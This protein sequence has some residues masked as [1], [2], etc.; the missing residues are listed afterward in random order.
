MS[1]LKKT[2]SLS[3]RVT[4]IFLIHTFTHAFIV[5]TAGTYFLKSKQSHDLSV[6]R[7]ATSVSLE[8]P[9]YP[10]ATFGAS[11]LYN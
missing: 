3:T 1:S 10:R 9:V 5:F 11:I 6:E 8:R 2:H 4:A 7:R